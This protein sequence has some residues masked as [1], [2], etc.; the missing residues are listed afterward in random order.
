M[1]DARQALDFGGL[2]DFDLPTPK[3]AQIQIV[4]KA[5]D[6]SATFPSREAIDDSQMN[7][8]APAEILERFRG[9]AKAERYRHG[10]FLQILMDAY[11]PK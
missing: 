7:I 11:A 10:E 1:A 4:K 9:L 6:Q 5:I 2:D 8:K 3:S